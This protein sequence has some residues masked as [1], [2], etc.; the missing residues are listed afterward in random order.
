MAWRL[1]TE[2]LSRKYI[3]YRRKQLKTSEI[4]N[5]GGFAGQPRYHIATTT[6]ARKKVHFHTIFHDK[7]HKPAAEIE[8]N[9]H[10]Y[11]R[12]CPSPFTKWNSSYPEGSMPTMIGGIVSKETVCCVGG[13]VKH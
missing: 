8:G 13:K 1:F 6:G 3:S 2:Q 11:Y 10:F 5:F 7:T 12:N 4:Y 9:V